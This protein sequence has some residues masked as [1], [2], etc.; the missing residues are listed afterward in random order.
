M[1]LHFM[2]MS[3]TLI[4]VRTVKKVILIILHMQT[5]TDGKLKGNLHPF[6]YLPSKL[7]SEWRY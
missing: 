3:I 1:W 7:G 2:V 4:N 5:H 6:S